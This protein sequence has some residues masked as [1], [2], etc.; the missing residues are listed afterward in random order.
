MKADIL[1]DKY[2]YSLRH[3]FIMVIFKYIEKLK[4]FQSEFPY[5]CHPDISL[6]FYCTCPITSLSM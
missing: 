6:I 5:V 3:Y 2:S 1:Q 4:E